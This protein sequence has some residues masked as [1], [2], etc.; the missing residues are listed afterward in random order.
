[1][2]SKENHFDCIMMMMIIGVFQNAFMILIISITI[3][4]TIITTHLN[5]PHPPFFS[6]LFLIVLIN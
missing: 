6:M 2:V 1:M 4:I 3:I 5:V